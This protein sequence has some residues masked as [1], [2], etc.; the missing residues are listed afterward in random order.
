[1]YLHEISYITAAIKS[2]ENEMGL[3]SNTHETDETSIQIAD[4]KSRRTREGNTKVDF[5]MFDSVDWIHV[6]H[7]SQWTAPV[8]MITIILGP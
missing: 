3:E 2:K 7:Q 1:M 5:K 6:A 4:E 8:N